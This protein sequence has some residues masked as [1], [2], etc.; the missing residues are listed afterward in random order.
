ME[1]ENLQRVDNMQ[2]IEA[3]ELLVGR[4]AHLRRFM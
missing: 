1:V 2:A 3:I 4:L